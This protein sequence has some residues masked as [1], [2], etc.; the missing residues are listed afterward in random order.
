MKPIMDKHCVTISNMNFYMKLHL[1]S[2]I[3][4][5]GPMLGLCSAERPAA[6]WIETMDSSVAAS[7]LGIR[8][9]LHGKEKSCPAAIGNL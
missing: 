7:W 3:R 1:E 8:A 5:W 4:F 9:L 2:L 6:L